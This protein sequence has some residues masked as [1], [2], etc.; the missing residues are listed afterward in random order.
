MKVAD[1][2][3]KH[4]YVT[5]EDVPLRQLAAQLGSHGISGM[6][7]V[8][9]DEVVGVI[10]EADVLAKTRRPAEPRDGVLDRLLHR[11]EEEDD[12]H[13]ATLVHEAMTRPAITVPSFCSV[14]T[15]ASRML[16]HNVNRLP[17]VDNARLV[18][19]VTR[20]DIVRAFARP[21]AAIEQ[22]ARETVEFQQQLGGEHA[23]VLVKVSDG[24]AMLTGAVRTEA[25]A[26]ALE[27]VVRDVPGVVSVRS[28]ITWFEPLRAA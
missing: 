20:A 1:V 16:E 12:K 5:T 24:E 3:S 21:D 7:V 19:I 18:G 4:V 26:R 13:D 14:A 9:D 11:G 27:R 6:P 10:S 22:D 23:A 28:E 17:V 25:Q 2:M 8:R 15:A